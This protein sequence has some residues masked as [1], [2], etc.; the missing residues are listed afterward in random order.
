MTVLSCDE[1]AKDNP[2]ASTTFEEAD[3][4]SV[5]IHYEITMLL[6]PS[7]DRSSEKA[8]DVGPRILAQR[9]ISQ[10]MRE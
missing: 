7:I 1:V 8:V 10:S 2:R 9:A 3:T 5:R 4:V 6:T